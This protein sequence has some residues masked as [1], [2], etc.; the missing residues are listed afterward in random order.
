[1]KK[2]IFAGLL[3]ALLLLS[4]AA[5]SEQTD[6][7]ASRDA[8]AEVQN[9]A[10]VQA[11]EEEPPEYLPPDVNYD[12]EDVTIAC[13]DYVSTGGGVWAAQNYCEG[14]AEEL[15]GD[16]LNDALYERNLTVEDELG[17]RIN[18]YPLT[19]YANSSS[20]LKT[21]IMA[22][23]TTIN[24]GMV[25]S[26]TLNSLLGTGMLVDFRSLDMDITHSWWDRT[27]V[28]E[29]TLFGKTMAITGDISLNA[30][31]APITF[32]FNKQLVT[33]YSLS[34]PYTLVRE[35][36]WT[37]DKSFDMC[38]AVA[39]DLNGNGKME[40]D[41]QFGMLCEPVSLFYLTQAAG[42]RITTK[43]A[44]GIPQSTLNEDR[45]ISVTEL[46]VPFLTDKNVNILS[47]NFSGYGNVFTEMML[48]MFKE[49]RALF[50]NNQLLVA[51]DLRNMDA[52]FGI[53]PAPKLTEEQKNYYSPYNAHWLT[54]AV[55]PSSCGNLDVTTDLIQSMGYWSS[56]K[57]TP[58]YI[59]ASVRYKTLRD[60]DS[61]AML[62]VILHNRIYDI[63]YLYDW[64][65]VTGIFS[66]MIS[67][68]TANFASKYASTEKLMKKQIEKTI[69]DLQD[70]E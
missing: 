8:S 67:S 60:E 50:Y 22:Q 3:A 20:E 2:R 11:A 36:S 47:S 24:Y 68:A 26:Q 34:D 65:G 40:I 70:E 33:D 23:D 35:S 41:D 4:T 9:A 31:F 39:S 53:V 15:N 5:C 18:I 43:D 66:G 64:G 48:P 16:V 21:L 56:A 44:D 37:M 6:S 28:E 63:G 1:M 25:S 42:V 55:I 52:D 30:G 49:N 27:E 59:D 69:K 29:L 62:D 17:V 7:E 14:Y 13:V 10:E 57:V 32:F 46:C 51:L 61:A 19:G 54:L 45:T 58:A 38:R 12:G